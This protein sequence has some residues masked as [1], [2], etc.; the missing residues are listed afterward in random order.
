M[1]TPSSPIETGAARPSWVPVLISA[2]VLIAKR[3]RKSA[4]SLL[5][6]T[7]VAPRSSGELTTLTQLQTQQADHLTR[8]NGAR[9]RCHHCARRG[10]EQCSYDA[11]LRRR[12]PGKKN[13]DKVGVAAGVQ[14][15]QQQQPKKA[16]SNDDAEMDED[17]SDHAS[18]E[19][20]YARGRDD[21]SRRAGRRSKDRD[22]DRDKGQAER[23]PFSYANSEL[24]GD[25]RH[26]FHPPQMDFGS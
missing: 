12:G 5:L 11:T 7:T 18:A 17:S 14:Q 21:V 4:R 2:W 10:E 13:K 15:E 8:C 3:K 19:M 25:P 23:L 22:R 24:G 1:I 26:G 16:R 9:P 6:V 20:E